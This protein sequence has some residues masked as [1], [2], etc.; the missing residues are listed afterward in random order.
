MNGEKLHGILEDLLA[1]TGASRCTLRQDLP[2]QGQAFPVTHEALGVEV[3]SLKEVVLDQTKQPVVEQVLRDRDQVIQDDSRAAFSGNREFERM[4][5][6]YGGLAAQIVTPV[7]AGDS[8]VGIISLHQL[9]TPRAW[10]HEEI[11]LCQRAAAQVAAVLAMR[12]GGP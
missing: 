5:E 3:G 6:V 4:R 1:R 9:N 7:L 12:A 2:D 10:S 8:V 11:Q